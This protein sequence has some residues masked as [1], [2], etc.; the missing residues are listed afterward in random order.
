MADALGPRAP[1]S[2]LLVRTRLLREL[3]RVVDIGVVLVQAPAGYGKTCLVASW[4]DQHANRLPVVW[5]LPGSDG[6]PDVGT[7]LADLAE[8]SQGG[9]RRGVVIVDDPVRTWPSPTVDR[10]VE[11]IAGAARDACVI[12]ATRDCRPQPWARLQ[13]AGRLLVLGPDVLA[14]D[15]ADVRELLRVVSGMPV[16]VETA[17]LVAGQVEGWA[18]AVQLAGEELRRRRG[19]PT[20]LAGWPSHAQG[21][22]RFVA[23][24]VVAGMD[25]KDVRFV[26]LT[27]GLPSLHPDLCDA[28]A[29]E[30]GSA[31]RL[32]RLVLAGVFTE[33]LP[34][35]AGSYRYHPLFA[36][37][38]ARRRRSSDP[39]G[40][41]AA[42]GHA[43]DWYRDAGDMDRAVEAG[44]RAADG[45]RVAA[46]LRAV[47]GPKLRGGEAAQ[48]VTWLER[49]PQAD[50]WSDPALSLALA[51]ACGL[52]GDSLT[53]RAVLRA[54]D[55]DMAARADRDL[56]LRI[57]RAQLESSVR[58]WEGRLATMGQP[59]EDVPEHLGELAHDP[60]LEICAIDETALTNSRVRA[61]I[62]VG[63]LDR[64]LGATDASLTPAEIQDPS[65]YTVVSVGLRAMALAWAGRDAEAR[66]AVRQG[67]RVLRRFRGT[68]TDPL[69]L[70]VAS[71]WVADGSDALPS[72]VR[73][74]EYATRS[75]LP[76]MRSLHAL[77]AVALN[78]RLGNAAE[79]SRAFV[80]AEREVNSLPEPAFLAVL[81]ERFRSDPRL[82]A[83]P[84]EA[85]SPQE[86]AMLRL[87]AQGA[88]RPRIAQ[89]T[90]YSVNTVKAYLRSAYRKLGAVDRDQA[91]AAAVA[92]GL[93]DPGAIAPADSDHEQG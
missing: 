17:A 59:L 36:E 68:G 85:L 65:R 86:V 38:M 75:G 70:H 82:Q 22:A 33:R 79:V 25:P 43:S 48:M 13:S 71:A 20:A 15:G 76:Y 39:Q 12:V 93:V 56:G 3:D 32:T 84:S 41:L 27:A 90:S 66:E 78:L 35:H 63:D 51:R 19:D 9:R 88:T 72:L 92:L 29:G 7:A 28:L 8:R 18:L 73:V 14:L 5:A 31:A 87:L 47:S 61:M 45:P 37:E 50:L 60:V 69:W 23:D 74:E 77:A 42:L 81:L 4:A 26:E 2:G 49:M 30:A 80:A 40:A 11:A 58:G 24:E 46:L 1:G 57:A 52:A 53:P 34:E 55:R 54:T 16:P 6:V 21:L 64:A 89:V 62:M 67:M 91:I 83:E 10:A 44:L